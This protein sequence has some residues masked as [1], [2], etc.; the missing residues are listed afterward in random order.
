MIPWLDIIGG[1]GKIADD[2]ITTDEERAKLALE[3][4][5][6]DAAL[7]GGQVETNKA[8]AAHASLFVAGWRPFIGWVGGVSLG[9]VYIPKALTLTGVWIYQA[10][11][12]YSHWDGT[13][14]GPVLPQYPDLG[15]TDLLGLLGSMLGFGVLRTYEKKQ[16]IETQVVERVRRGGG[17]DES[18][19]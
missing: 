19:A 9:M 12:L 16:G 11:T 13:G 6:I 4:R 5:R 7:M 10:V 18:P 1:V 17:N 3:D 15:V 8:E 14:V 2:L